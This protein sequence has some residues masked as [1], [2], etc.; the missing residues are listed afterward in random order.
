MLNLLERHALGLGHHGLHPNELK[1]HHAGEEGEDV[2]RRE[3]VDHW[4]E[5][6]GEQRREYPM[7]EA[8]ECL[9]FCA[10]TVGED[11]RDEDPDDRALTD[12][13]GRDESEDADGHDGVM[14][15]E[16]RPRNQA[17]RDDVANGADIKQRAPAESIDQPQSNEREDQ[18]GESD[19]D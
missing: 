14:L 18:V 7:C 12:G 4:R 16:E 17:E 9:A 5:K 13:M 11:F 10:V 8:A 15:G 6:R 19:S 3:D 2:A 1:H